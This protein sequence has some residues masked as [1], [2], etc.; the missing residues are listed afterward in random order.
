[1]IIEE[2]TK[3]GFQLDDENLVQEMFSQCNDLSGALDWLTLH[4]PEDQL[5]A[6]FRATKGKQKTNPFDL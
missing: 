4:L 1:M 6:H 2:L 5:P 3:L